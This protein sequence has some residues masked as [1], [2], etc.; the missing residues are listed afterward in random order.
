MFEHLNERLTELKEK[1]R[2]QEKWEKRRNHLKEELVRLEQALQ[3]AN[4]RLE[5]EEKDV[6]RL[7]GVSISNFLYTLAGKKERKLDEEQ[8]EAVA[9]RLKYEEADRAVRDTQLQ[10]ALIDRQLLEIAGWKNDYDRVFREKEQQILDE[11]TE[12]RELAERQADLGV[13]AKELNE[14]IRAGRS[15][16]DDLSRA[17]EE[18]QSARNWG[19]YDMLGG[20][21]ISTHIKHNR[22]DE[23]MNRIYAAQTNLRRFEQELRDVGGS[24]DASKLEVGGLL[25]FSDFFFDGFLADWLVQGRINDALDQVLAKHREVSRIVSELSSA[26]RGIRNELDTVHRKYVQLVERYE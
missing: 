3:T 10:I 8:R 12:L 26:E 9:A 5:E 22:L 19:T 24:L 4:H 7:T 2:Q 15:V 11:N 6:E 21:M 20:G 17:E 13:E 18:L 16:Q 1:G 25:R 23:A 14:A